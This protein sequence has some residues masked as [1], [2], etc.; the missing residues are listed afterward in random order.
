MKPAG[1]ILDD[2]LIDAHPVVSASSADRLSQLLERVAE[3]DRALAMHAASRSR[4]IEQARVWASGSDDI[5]PPGARLSDRDRQEWVRRSFVAEIACLLRMPERSA[6]RLIDESEMLVNELPATL[7]ALALAQISYRH[8]QIVL[9]QARTLPD[10]IRAAFE[11]AVLGAA[12]NLTVSAFRKKTI[13]MR[14]RMHPD[15]IA[16]RCRRAVTERRFAIE[17]DC[18]GMA[19]L[20]HYLPVTQ[21]TGIFERVTGLARSLQGPGETRT[22]EHLR[23]DV[24]GELL[25]DGCQNPHASRGGDD[26]NGNSARKHGIRPTVIVTVP[27][28]TLLG[29]SEELGELA[30][31]G[32][33]DPDTARELAA[34]APSFIRL[35][36][37][38][39]TGVV[40]SVGRDRYT[41]PPDL[42]TW[43]QIRDET[44]RFPG[45]QRAVRHC[46]IDHTSAWRHE[47][48][49]AADN[50]A[51]LCRAHHR[52]KHQ[53]TWRL[54]QDRHGTLEWTTPSGRSYKTRPA[55][56]LHGSAPP[57]F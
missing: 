41:V 22:L 21:A 45:C 28:M 2:A 52:L 47:G 31:Y 33:I 56:E 49:T 6:E 27:V 19:W 7:N 42:R 11:V 16:E 1:S 14:E 55:V 8:A 26:G 24:A 13:R 57:P 48:P 20:H 35:L 39:E 18:D 40:L 5:V 34:H 4:S 15:S 3:D 10:T 17:P 50:L 53:T 25:L 36:T 32:P 29:R 43:L 12:P 44:C 30:G 38:P 23:A 37:H 46:D 54:S 51:H 9:D